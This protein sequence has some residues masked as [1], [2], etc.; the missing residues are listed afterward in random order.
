[1]TRIVVSINSGSNNT[2]RDILRSFYD[3]MTY[4]YFHEYDVSDLR[5][6]KKKHGIDLRLNYEC[7]I[8][9]CD[10]AVQFGTVKSR[11]AEHHIVKKSIQQHA[12]T[13]IFIETPVLGRVIN[14]KNQY[15]YYRVGIDGFLNNQG[16][17]CDPESIDRQRLVEL[18]SR[19]HVPEFPGWKDHTQGNI[20]IL[21]QLPG[22][23]SLRGQNMGEW[24]L[25]T[26]EVLRN[27]TSRPIAIRFHPAMS[28]KGRAEFFGEIGPVLF[29]NYQDI[30]WNNGI[31][32][33]LEEDLTDAGVCVTY[34]SGSS[35]DAILAGVPV[36]AIDEGNLAYPI[37][38]HRLSQVTDPLL[39]DVSAI[40]EWL[41]MLANS[42]W[43]QQEMVTGATWKHIYNLLNNL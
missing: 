3:G 18:K 34:S 33:T 11:T 36:I 28:D 21:L 2:E 16:I 23:A 10:I 15:T 41:H 42:Q 24:L 35:I 14:K 43:T 39:A 12:N 38:S 26:L 4:F 29:E 37:S 40:T 30:V 8:E 31:T 22:D 19:L 13:I 20:L 9:S 6:L 7:E 1:M 32:R 25:D 17:F 5:A 27:T